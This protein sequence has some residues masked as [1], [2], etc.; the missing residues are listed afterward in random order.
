MKYNR[1][2]IMKSAWRTYRYSFKKVGKTFGQALSQAW[3][4]AKIGANKVA[5][6][7]KP[8]AV[9]FE[10]KMRRLN[11]ALAGMKANQSNPA[12]RDSSMDNV[13]E[14]AFYS[15]STHRG[16]RFVND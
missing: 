10:E 4:I 8:V 2:Q 12:T 6:K 14:S 11:N 15:N 16:G 9:S 1:S 7:V 5:E 3:E 13:P